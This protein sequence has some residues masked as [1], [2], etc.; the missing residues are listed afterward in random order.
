MRKRVKAI[1]ERW[2]QRHDAATEDTPEPA[3]TDGREPAA[4]SRQQADSG[5]EESATQTPQSAIQ[6]PHSVR[7]SRATPVGLGLLALLAAVLAALAFAPG[8]RDTTA[9][10]KLRF[11]E[12]PAPPAPAVPPGQLAREA[13]AAQAKNPAGVITIDQDTAEALGLQ[14]FTVTTQDLSQPV[15][16]TGRVAPDERRMTTVHTKV[17]GW[18]EEAY[19]NFEGQQIHKGQKLFTI[20][21]PDLVATQQEYLIALRAREDFKG[22]EFDV[23]Q[24]SGNTLV[25]ATRR[26]LQLWDVTPQQIAELERTR[27]VFRAV[28]FYAP[29]SG[30][31]IGRQA[32]PGMRV[33]AET[34]LYKLADLSAV[35]VEAD[36]FQSD[37][38]QIQ[39]GLT[40]EVT[41]PD[42]A[43]QTGRVAF[44]A[45]FIEPATRTAKVRLEFANPQMR[46]RPGMFVNVNLKT[47]QPPNI[48]VPRDAV[49]DTGTR[50]LVLL[51]SG[52]G[53]YKL[54]EIKTGAPATDYYTVLEGV[55]V[56]EKV[57]RNIQFLIDSETQL[58]QAVDRLA[59]PKT[60]APRGTDAMPNM[61]GMSH[62]GGK[63]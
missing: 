1:R 44:I 25:E 29:A 58:K 15:R 41:T 5:S 53:Q 60:P 34:E 62:E 40:G 61:P 54:R 59:E 49:I 30:V 51:A 52:N 46:L 36:V 14:T 56:G 4:G 35:W 17:E 11:W 45:P 31:V 13:E 10:R 8:L 50:Q 16:T 18:I 28:P 22:S 39:V 55:A 57:A 19:G 2:R 26:R 9:G 48:I 43:T 47:Y 38:P 12:K 23:I 37:L 21:S 42:N 63:P 20:Y 24:R 7:R 32:F 33:T 3:E 6:T 27:K